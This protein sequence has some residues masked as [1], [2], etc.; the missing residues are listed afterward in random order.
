MEQTL[1]FSKVVLDA[2]KQFIARV[3]AHKTI[4]EATELVSF[5]TEAPFYFHPGQYIHLRLFPDRENFREFSR[6]FS[7]ASPCGTDGKFDIAFRMSASPFKEMLLA[8]PRGSEVVFTGPYGNFIPPLGAHALFFIAG[9]IGITP[10]RSIIQGCLHTQAL[11]PTTLLY[12]NRNPAS[13]AFVEEFREL[14]DN[15]F[16]LIEHYGPFNEEVLVKKADAARDAYVFI[17]GPPPMVLLT[18]AALLKSGIAE[19]RIRTEGF[20][21]YDT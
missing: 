10:F 3:T 20:T 13:A 21:G 7:I 11:P 1:N 15:N 5:E 4:A 14:R 6:D 19:E 12:A 9:G 16:T 8:L 2:P 17:A 18:A